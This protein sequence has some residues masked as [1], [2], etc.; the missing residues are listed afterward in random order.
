[1]KTLGTLITIFA[2]ILLAGFAGFEDADIKAFAVRIV[3]AALLVLVGCFF[4]MIGGRHD[5]DRRR[6]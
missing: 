1:M 2:M 3:F 6:R 4:T 5:T